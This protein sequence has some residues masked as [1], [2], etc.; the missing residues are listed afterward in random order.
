MVYNCPCHDSQPFRSRAHS[1]PG[2]NRPIGPWPI[3]SLELSLPGPFA[4]WPSSSLELS[5][6]GASWPGNFHSLELSHSRV[7]APRNI[8]SLELSFPVSFVTL[9]SLYIN[10]YSPTIVY[11][12]FIHQ[13]LVVHTHTQKNTQKTNLNKLN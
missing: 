13:E 7:F 11:K 5:F 8:R 2:A 1:L 3:R 10:L 9:V 12:S 4:P 6:P